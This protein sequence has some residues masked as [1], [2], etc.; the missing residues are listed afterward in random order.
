[1]KLIKKFFFL[2]SGISTS[3][4]NTTSSG[5][6]ANISINT[7][8]S[9]TSSS[10]AMIQTTN[11]NSTTNMHQSLQTSQH[12]AMMLNVTHSETSQ[13][14]ITQKQ[15]TKS[16][17]IGGPPPGLPPLGPDSL[18]ITNNNGE[19]SFLFDLNPAGQ[20]VY[21]FTFIIFQEFLL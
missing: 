2:N 20:A 15:E 17:F 12:D 14:T 9:S 5:T 13:A 4:S 11:I 8:S 10:N 6:S 21:Y 1:M 16:E 19:E 3:T 18:V 7:S